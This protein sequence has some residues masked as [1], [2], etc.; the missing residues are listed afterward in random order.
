MRANLHVPFLALSLAAAGACSSPHPAADAAAGAAADRI[1]VNG[2]VLT[3][4]DAQPEAEALAVKDGKIVAVG[5]RAEIERLKGAG[6]SVTD[7]TGT[8]LL[9]GFI[10]A[11]GHIAD[12]TTQ[13]DTPTLSPPP[14]GDVRSI[15][16]IQAKL[17]KY[18]ADTKATKDRLV[19]A[20]GYDDGQL[21][22]LRHPTRV[23]LDKVSTEVPILLV[24]ASGHLVVANTPALALAGY[25]RASKDPPG[26]VIRR[27]KDGTPDGVLEEKAT[28]AF[29]PFVPRPSMEEQLGALDAVQ[30]WY[31]S[32]GITTAQDG[33]SNPANI[34]L[35][36]R[37][38]DER[39]LILDVVSYPMWTLFDKV[40]KGEQKL[41]NVEYYRPGSQVTN[42]GR[43]LASDRPTPTPAAI[44]DSA[45]AKLKVGVYQN[46]WKIAG[47]KISGD[48][49][50][51]GKTAYMTKPYLRPPPGQPAEY[52]AYPV[53]D[54]PEMDQ[55]LEAAY[56]HD[57]PLLVHTN[58]DAEIDILLRAV[59]KAR[60]KHGPKDLRPVAIHAQLARHDQVDS[61]KALGIVPSF[62][63][64][65]TFFWGDWHANEVFGKERAFGISPLRY[66]E[67]VGL[68]FTNHNDSPVVPP[69]MMMLAW[70]AVNRLS[71][72]GVV[73]GPDERVSP[74]TALK[75]MTSSAAYQY[76]EENEK[77][78]L[79]PGK[80]ADLVILGENPLTVRAEAIKDILVVETIKDG[81]T[82]YTAAAGKPRGPGA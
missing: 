49:S 45:K 2:H 51:Q 18:L 75:A 23:E 13:W 37:A 62:F 67:S 72:S 79:E 15:A 53:V 59:S 25:T 5:T 9:P 52:R 17:T 22:E 43:G 28:Y 12:Y 4:N 50:P 74:L 66:A 78:T 16:D 7:L 40:L 80:R 1:F 30:R 69:D 33:L 48:G 39:R 60:A 27:E 10:D 61:M 42:A 21:K 26:G 29:L 11:H 68:T 57:V 64:A 41:E 55:W 20:Q 14:V 82:I 38:S 65:H 32:Y 8:T 35:L 71:R 58:G 24:H 36:K 47:I 73:I 31:A 44:G 76:F 77:G 54:Q 19:I 56:K 81:R 46:G 6:T 3:M 63:T 34:A 70:T